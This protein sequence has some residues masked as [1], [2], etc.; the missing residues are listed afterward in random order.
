MTF[1][2]SSVFNRSDS[3]YRQGAFRVELHRITECWPRK[4]HVQW[5]L[6]SP[7][8]ATG[9]SFN[10]YRSEGENG[11][12]EQVA[13][14]LEDTYFFVDTDFPADSDRTTPDIMTLSRVLSYKITVTHAT[15]GTSEHI[16]QVEAGLDK[17]RRGILRKL[18]RD[19]YIMLKRGSGTEVAILKRMWYGEACTCKSKSGQVVRAHHAECNG[20]GIVHGYWDPVYTYASHDASPV[21]VQTDTQG[22]VESHFLQINIPYIPA[23]SKYDII[24]YLR[25]NRRF[26]V[27]QVLKTAIHSVPVHQELA[28]SELARPSR[29]YDL[30]VDPWR[31]PKWF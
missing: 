23:V 1:P 11:P 14:N 7:S 26:I 27:D 8:S 4:V 30:E 15:D 3:P 16:M 2:P 12:W 25:D 9:Y 10:I 18:R 20:T 19:A 6:K 28:V 17:R 22:S 31:D 29:E 13:E 24:V 5:V 21:T